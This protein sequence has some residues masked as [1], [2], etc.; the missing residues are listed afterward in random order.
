MTG[1]IDLTCAAE[2]FHPML[3]AGV[4]AAAAGWW[5]DGVQRGCLVAMTGA[6]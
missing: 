6:R 5:R 3:L 4:S 1:V 2:N